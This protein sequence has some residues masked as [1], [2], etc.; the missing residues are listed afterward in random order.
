MTGIRSTDDSLIEDRRTKPDRKIPTSRAYNLVKPR[1][2]S[3]SQS[4]IIPPVTRNG[5]SMS[6]EKK[7][8]AIYRQ[9]PNPHNRGPM[10]DLGNESP[11]GRRRTQGPDKTTRNYSGQN[12]GGVWSNMNGTEVGRSKT[13]DSSIVL[14]KSTGDRAPMSNLMK[15]ARAKRL[16]KK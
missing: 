15:A 3:T 7:Y 13:E 5:V 12:K 6:D 10:N 14:G 2:L 4:S 9:A 8:K 16:G 11:S 1:L